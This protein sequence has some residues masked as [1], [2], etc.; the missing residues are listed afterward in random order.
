MQQPNE[1]GEI[2]LTYTTINCATINSAMNVTAMQ[3]LATNATAIA[4]EIPINFNVA[5]AESSNEKQP[6]E[7]GAIASSTGLI[8]L[9]QSSELANTTIN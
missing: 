7:S 6:S 3:T 8:D 9:E 1:S 4:C 2:A 5:T